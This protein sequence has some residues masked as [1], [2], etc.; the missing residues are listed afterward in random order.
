MKQPSSDALVFFGATGM[1]AYE[2]LLQDAMKGDATLFA[3]EDS[4]EQAWRIVEPILGTVTPVF[5]YAPGTWGPEE[6]QQ[7]TAGHSP[8]HD[9]IMA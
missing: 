9:P 6:A 8:W 2:R 7:I 3:R 1:D 5:E 4:V